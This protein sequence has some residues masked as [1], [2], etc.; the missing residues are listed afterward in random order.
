MQLLDSEISENIAPI[1]PKNQTIAMNCA[2][3]CNKNIMKVGHF[4]DKRIICMAISK[5]IIHTTIIKIMIHMT[6]HFQEFQQ[7]RDLTLIQKMPGGGG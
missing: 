2:S 5:D 1:V 6:L 3:T 4:Q 7:E